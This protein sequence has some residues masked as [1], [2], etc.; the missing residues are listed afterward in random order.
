MEAEKNGS[1]DPKKKD[2]ATSQGVENVAKAAVVGTAATAAIGAFAPAI[3]LPPPIL[4]GVAIG[5][6]KLLKWLPDSQNRKTDQ[7]SAD[8]PRTEVDLSPAEA[9]EGSPEQRLRLMAEWVED[10]HHREVVR[11]AH[12][13]LVTLTQDAPLHSSVLGQFGKRHGIPK[14]VSLFVKVACPEILF[15]PSKQ[16][17]NGSPCFVHKDQVA[18]EAY[19]RKMRKSLSISQLAEQVGAWNVL[20]IP[21][22]GDETLTRRV[23]IFWAFLLDTYGAREWHDMAKVCVDFR[24]RFGMAFATFFSGLRPADLQRRVDRDPDQ[25]WGVAKLQWARTTATP[26]VL[27]VC[28]LPPNDKIGQDLARTLSPEAFSAL[29]AEAAK[30]SP[31]EIP[32]ETLTERFDVGVCTLYRAY[33]LALER[34]LMARLDGKQDSGIASEAVVAGISAKLDELSGSIA[35]VARTL[36]EASA[37]LTSLAA[38]QADLVAKLREA[39]KQ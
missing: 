14:P 16:S 1:S 30:C 35:A 13:E 18:E 5:V 19:W 12:D 9:Q 7:K 31:E 37:R 2:G 3:L 34:A 4:A 20:G 32:W 23:L 39:T 29:T 8:M 15:I 25:P 38:L 27:S 36:S 10:P 6:G 24:I 21:M 33:P 17:P 22:P 26:P 28:A 11:L